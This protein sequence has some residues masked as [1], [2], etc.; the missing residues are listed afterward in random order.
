MNRLGTWDR[1]RR[2]R[3]TGIL[4]QGARR[5]REAVRGPRVYHRV[6]SRRPMSR[7][8]LVT[9]VRDPPGEQRLSMERYADEL[10]RGIQTQ[11]SY[12]AAG[13]ALPTRSASKNGG[14]GK[15][16]DYWDRLIRF[17]VA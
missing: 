17:P 3:T 12:R 9:L 14:G 16:V 8:P 4:E 10:Y 1:S 7:P 6:Y 2:C 15:L 13:F 5:L 11:S